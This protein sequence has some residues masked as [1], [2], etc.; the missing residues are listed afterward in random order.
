MQ[1]I[2]WRG[3]FTVLGVLTVLATAAIFLVVPEKEG[4]HSGE[5]MGAQVRGIGR[6]F[7]SPLFWSVVPLTVASQAS[8]MAIQ[9]LWVGPWLRDMAGFSR[10]AIAN[11]LLLMGAAMVVGFIVLGGG[12]ER[13]GRIGVRPI[14]VGV[15]GMT[16]FVAV[17]GVI[18]SG[19]TGAVVPVW[20]VFGFLGTAGILPYAGLSQSFPPELAGRVITGINVLV[21]CGAFLAQWGIGAIINQWPTT[22]DGGYAADGYTAGFGAVVALQAAA[23]L[24]Y[25]VSPG[26]RAARR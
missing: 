25:L 9:S 17:Q 2:D 14:T 18:V 26:R 3:V 16:A 4:S 19:W 6:V 1:I 8:F 22:A 15:V 5:T 7:S 12:A 23:V 24:W 13:L 10:V 11:Q 20:L 21:F